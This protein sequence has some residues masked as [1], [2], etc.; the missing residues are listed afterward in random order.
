[1]R[2]LAVVVALSG[3]DRVLGFD[4]VRLPG[5][6]NADVNCA[7]LVDFDHDCVADDVDNCP[8]NPNPDQ[9]DVMDSD[10]VGDACDPH[11]QRPGDSIAWF[12]TFP[13]P[14]AAQA[15]WTA[16]F[17]A[18]WQFAPGM[19][20]H[21]D[22]MTDPGGYLQR[23]AASSGAGFTIEA[24]FTFHAYGTVTD[25]SR[26]AVWMDA[27][28]GVDDGQ[29]CWATPYNNNG[30]TTLLD[31]VELQ[32]EQEVPGVTRRMDMAALVDGDRVV[33]RLTRDTTALTCKATVNGNLAALDT[34]SKTVAW[35][36][37]GH[38]AVQVPQADAVV[39]YVV[40]YAT[41]NPP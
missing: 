32:E 29:G 19:L 26:L 11:P 22:L 38:I 20:V 3:C 2:L 1:M 15:E 16:L 17:G 25:A 5:D 23:V 39:T 37:G 27:S 14:T 7:A 13:D 41:T 18:H 12:T 31:S 6:A 35:R 40:T 30:D 33:M 21:T 8:A 24:G 28:A 34:L 9:L 36:T 10:G 4:T